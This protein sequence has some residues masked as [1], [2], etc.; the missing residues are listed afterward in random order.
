MNRKKIN[1]L[2]SIPLSELYN[3]LVTGTA[4]AKLLDKKDGVG[5]NGYIEV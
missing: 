1:K 2:I 4:L 3:I 5:Q